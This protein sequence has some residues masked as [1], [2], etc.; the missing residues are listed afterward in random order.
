MGA[1]MHS[2]GAVAWA[3]AFGSPAFSKGE[4]ISIPGSI[5][6]TG[7]T[8]FFLMYL[9]STSQIHGGPAPS[10][11]L[12]PEA[13]SELPKLLES[14]CV[15]ALMSDLPSKFPTLGS[16]FTPAML[17][18]ANA[19]PWAS[20]SLADVPGQVHSDVPTLIVQGRE[21]KL[22]S[23][24]GSRCLA[25]RMAGLHSP[26]ETCA[27]DGGHLEIVGKSWKSILPW[28]TAVTHGQKPPALPAE[29][30]TTPLPDCK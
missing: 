13:Q 18:D 9:W 29:C 15:Q 12:T 27:L 25:D 3:P 24:A 28:I 6:T 19:E 20:Y 4:K 17:A 7:S 5:P 30:T 26:V 2:A 10:A 14:E 21:D 23:A 16:I 8:I 22:V 1:G 11:W